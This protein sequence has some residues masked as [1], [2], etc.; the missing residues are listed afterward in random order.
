[1]PIE[2]DT[3]PVAMFEKFMLESDSPDY[4]MS[5]VFEFELAGQLDSKRLERAIERCVSRHP[6]LFATVDAGQKHWRFSRL[7]TPLVQPGEYGRALRFDLTSENGLRVVVPGP[8]TEARR[9]GFVFHH[10]CVDGLGAFLF[11]SDVAES[12]GDDSDAVAQPSPQVAI[13]FLK[14]FRSS[15][16]GSRLFHC[17]RWPVDLIGMLWSLELVLNRPTPVEPELPIPVAEENSEGFRFGRADQV[18]R[19]F[20]RKQTARVRQL[21]RSVGQTL[22]DRVIQSVFLGIDEWNSQFNPVRQGSLIR[23]MVPMNLRRGPSISAANMVAMVNL[24]RKVG[25][26]KSAKWFRRILRLEMLAVKRLRAGV[27]ANRYMQ[28]HR[29]ILRRWPLQD[30]HDRCWTSCLVSNLG[31][32]SRLLGNNPAGTFH[33]G[34]VTATNFRVIAPLRP[35]SNIFVGVFSYLD[36][37]NLNLTFNAHVLDKTH[38][39]F[40]LDSIERHLLQDPLAS[41]VSDDLV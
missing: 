25:R 14:R 32:L 3:L 37:L 2:N 39:E 30:H 11:I 9:I 13:S 21:S 15:Y 1:M 12:Y 26:W 29:A 18:D 6:L 17:L 36:R 31:D 10:A 23:L 38:I 40:L 5:F 24:D 34:D 33:F 28:L 27:T 19:I 16:G 20:T 35:N 22:N 41:S 8:A 7:L 4:P